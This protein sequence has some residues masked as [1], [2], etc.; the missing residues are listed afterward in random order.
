MSSGLMKGQY[1][2]GAASAWERIVQLDNDGNV[3][4]SA[5]SGTDL[6]T[7]LDAIKTALEIID[8]WD[9]SDYCKS[10]LYGNDGASNVIAK[11]DSNGQ[12]YILQGAL[13]P[14]EDSGS[15]YRKIKKD[16]IEAYAPTKTSTG[17]VDTTEDEILAS[18]D[19]GAFPNW[20]VYVKNTGAAALTDVIVYTSPDGTNWAN[21][22]AAKST[23]ES[24]C[25]TLAAGSTGIAFTVSGGSFKYVKVGATCG[26][27]TSV[28]CWLVAN[29]G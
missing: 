1:N 17:T 18:V 6:R 20:T 11:M 19:V 4:I 27:S 13:L 25:E 15:D 23:I 29:V 10:E 5:A 9:N 28:D 14:G 7:L 2:K 22:D 24:A 26:T 3:I 16:E 21:M 8:D 12:V